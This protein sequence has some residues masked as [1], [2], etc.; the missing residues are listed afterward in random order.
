MEQLK[1]ETA[2]QH[3]AIEPVLSSQPIVDAACSAFETL[4][5]GLGPGRAS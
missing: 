4:T 3:A 5:R 1:K 2:A